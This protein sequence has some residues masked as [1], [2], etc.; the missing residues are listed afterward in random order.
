M[1]WV[2]GLAHTKKKLAFVIH[3]QNTGIQYTVLKNTIHTEMNAH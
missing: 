1:D 2:L 3:T